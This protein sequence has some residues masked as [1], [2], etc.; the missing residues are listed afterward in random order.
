MCVRLAR[1][2]EPVH[3]HSPGFTFQI[4]LPVSPGN[5]RYRPQLCALTA[6]QVLTQHYLDQVSV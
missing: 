4:V 6:L 2:T 5:I 3:Q 1:I